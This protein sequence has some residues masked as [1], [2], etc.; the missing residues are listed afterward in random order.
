MHRLIMN[1]QPQQGVDHIDG[2]R[3]NNQ[4]SNLRCCTQKQ[5]CR[6]IAKDIGGTSKFKGVLR[7]KGR[8]TFRVQIREAALP[9][10]CRGRY[11]T[12]NS[13]RS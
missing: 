5:N 1:P 10:R 9:T 4:R 13:K 12:K 2:R 11:W 7:G 6:N 3:L 8:Q